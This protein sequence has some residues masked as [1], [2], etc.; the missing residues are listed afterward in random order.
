MPRP[1]FPRPE[2]WGYLKNHLTAHI[3]ECNTST[4]DAATQ[5]LEDFEPDFSLS[6]PLQDESWNLAFDALHTVV[7]TLIKVG[8]LTPLKN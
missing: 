8:I 3:S 6:R 7:T 1:T 2:T 4:K 5:K